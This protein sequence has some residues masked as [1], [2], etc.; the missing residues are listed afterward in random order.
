M[1]SN[2]L[3]AGYFGC[4]NLGDDAIL[5]GLTE[6]LERED[7]ELTMLSGAPEESFRN[8][9]IP[10]I[11]RRDTRQLQSAIERCDLLVF[12]GGSVFQDVTSV[13]SPA[14]YADLVRRA[15]KAKK[16]VVLLS[17]GVGPLKSFFGRRAAVYAFNAAD[18]AVVRDPDSAALL[19]EIGVRSPVR[20]GAD[21]S[22]LMKPR[23]A[24]EMGEFKV[25]GMKTVGI[26][27]RPYGRHAKAITKLFGDLARRLFEANFMPVLIE[28]DRHEDG[29]LIY[30]ISKQQGGKVPDIRKL[31]TPMQ[32]QQRMSRMEAVIAMRLHAG[33]L[34]ANV[35]VPPFMVSYDPKVT[36]FAKML[37]LHQAVSI[38]GLK[39]DR[40]FESFMAFMRDRERNLK[41][42]ERRQAHLV[43]LAQVNIDT[44]K[45]FL[46]S[47]AS[48]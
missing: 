41:V 6:G 12:P 43:K 38:E 9:G 13:R 29:P 31:D 14:Y 26:A 23:L 46:K 42:L 18:A 8:Y 34:A 3:L 47:P 15:K 1:S 21:L 19:K 44:L 16:K 39:A 4:G 48:A 37:E 17:Q 35:F 25:G 33:I 22:F 7:V 11:A 40:L 20:L 2:L 30:D 36:A 27:P 10:S 45:A 28:M 32:V 5:M 24:S